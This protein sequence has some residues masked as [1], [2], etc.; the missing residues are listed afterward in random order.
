MLK[1]IV[2]IL[3]ISDS[4]VF[5]GVLTLD[6]GEE[7]WPPYSFY[8][9]K[10]HK[11]IMVEVLENLI[12]DEDLEL[13]IS[14]LPELRASRELEH[15]NVDAKPKAMEWIEHPKKYLWSDP[16]VISQ[17]IV[18]TRKGNTFTTKD[19]LNGKIIGTVRGYSYPTLEKKFSDHIMLRA[20]ASS[21]LKML[22]MLAKGHTDAAITNLHV[23]KWYLK[24]QSELATNLIS[25][26][27]IIDQAPYRFQ[28]CTSSEWTKLMPIINKNIAKLK[29]SGELDQ[30]LKRYQ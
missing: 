8:R 17:D 25:T 1:L 27:V 15:C 6:V 26:K 5:A 10:T 30:I 7:A 22:E 21:T 23:F 4:R 12:A 28:F 20:D 11:G 18:V 3:L 19:Q 2:F 29:N 24:N 14:F 13:K 9:D 16:V